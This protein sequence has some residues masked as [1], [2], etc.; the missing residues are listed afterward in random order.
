MWKNK[1]QELI[2]RLSKQRNFTLYEC[3]INKSI[4]DDLISRITNEAELTLPE[5]LLFFYREMNGVDV[6]WALQKDDEEIYGS[7][8]ILPFQ[9][10]VF[11]YDGSIQRSQYENA[12]EDVLW[13]EFYSDKK[14]KELKQHRLFESIEGDSAFIT[15]RM[16]DSKIQLFYVYEE[17]I[18]PLQVSLT[19]YLNL[20]IQYIGAGSIREH[21][22]SKQW[23]QKINK[24]KVLRFIAGQHD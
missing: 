24:D 19:D 4:D 12:F 23:K 16:L 5:E 3:K 21:L 9:E 22:K 10:A 13:N 15:F 14:V 17:E 1:L 2:D 6:S 20:I 11:G 18:K 8:F 7:I